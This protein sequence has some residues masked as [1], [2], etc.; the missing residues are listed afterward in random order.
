MA[1]TSVV[2]TSCSEARIVVVRSIAMATSMPAG[3][4]ASSCGSAAFT[5][6]T[7]SMMLA[8]GWR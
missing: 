7:V 8:L 3:I 6:S 5:R 2:S 4:D 1:M